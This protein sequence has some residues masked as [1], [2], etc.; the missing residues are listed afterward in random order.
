MLLT[1]VLQRG[2]GGLELGVFF[3]EFFCA[4]AAEAYGDAA[5]VVIVAFDADYG[6]YTEF[7]MPDFAAE[8]GIVAGAA[9]GRGP[10]EAAWRGR[11]ARGRRRGRGFAAHT[12]KEL[13]RKSTRL[14]SS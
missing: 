9:P 1:L 3:D 13:D 14:H 6:A 5:V 10:A 12:A 4:A 8:H 11:P 7:G 2:L